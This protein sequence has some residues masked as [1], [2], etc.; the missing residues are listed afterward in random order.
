MLR[1]LKARP[2][3]LTSCRKSPFLSVLQAPKT[4][5]PAGHVVYK[6]RN[7]WETFHVQATAVGHHQWVGRHWAS[8]VAKS[9]PVLKMKGRRKSIPGAG[10]IKYKGPA[11]EPG[12]PE[13]PK[14]ASM[15][16]VEETL[17][18]KYFVLIRVVGQL[19][20][21][22]PSIGGFERIAT[23]KRGFKPVSGYPVLCKVLKLPMVWWSKSMKG[24]PM[25]SPGQARWL[26]PRLVHLPVWSLVVQVSLQ[27]IT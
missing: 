16:R 3:W 4:G 11:V 26:L 22:A 17:G 2:Q 10:S 27:L 5:S 12:K 20:E 21:P 1:H 14:G 6:H 9:E 23:G 24:C 8:P 13:G 15:T 19:M 7:L 18:Q 25:R